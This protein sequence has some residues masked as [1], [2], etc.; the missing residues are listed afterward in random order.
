MQ[1]LSNS[2]L[3][4]NEYNS[5]ILQIYLDYLVRYPNAQLLDL[6]PVCEENIM[7]FAQRVRKVFACDM[8]FRIDKFRR[9]GLPIKKAWNDLNYQPHNFN[10][11][12]LW[13]FIDHLDNNDAVRLAE[14]CYKMIKSKGVLL[15]ISFNEQSVLPQIYS[16]VIQENCRMTL[17]QQ[18]HLDLPW[19]YRNIRTLMSLLSDFTPVKTFLYRNG[20]REMLF[21]RD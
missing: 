13:D 17:R 16:F 9:K 19:Y 8:F 14:M 12:H 2:E 3:P 11:I 18:P 5:K 20:I 10:G 1:N 6:G 15:A 4:L 21:Y 7:F